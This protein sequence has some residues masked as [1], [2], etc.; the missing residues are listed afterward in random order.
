MIV[1]ASTDYYVKIELDG[2]QIS[3]FKDEGTDIE[4]IFHG[5]K[6]HWSYTTPTLF[7]IVGKSYD[8]RYHFG[9][10]TTEMKQHGF[11]RD[12]KF[13]LVKHKDKTAV[14]E[15]T[16]NEDT[17]SKFPYDFTMRI[18][19]TLEGNKL[20]VEYEIT[21]NGDTV[22]PY[23]FGLHPAFSCPLS[24]DKTFS[25]YSLTFSSPQKLKGIGPRVN[26]GLVSEIPLSYEGFEEEN[27][28]IY[29]NVT[30]SQVGFS[31]GE[32]GVNVSVVGYPLVGVWTNINTQSPFICIEPWQ[33]YG[34][35]LEK[36]VAFE[37]RDAIMELSPKRKMLYT[38]TI[39]VF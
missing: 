27:T 22:M 37:E 7:P 17:L 24:E 34:K 3:R 10:K 20:L 19:Y 29:H 39:E 15:F 36:D 18:S 25:D 38:Y 31:D 26:D 28:W 9:N 11:M 21:N 14:L 12:V 2:G 13:N 4:Y 23:N 32:H 35:R 33:G 6:K 16:A 30:S 8:N 1:L 5:D